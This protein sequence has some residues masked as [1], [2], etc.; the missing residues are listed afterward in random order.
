MPD[1]AFCSVVEDSAAIAGW[2]IASE[3]HEPARRRMVRW[4]V[5]NQTKFFIGKDVSMSK[6]LKKLSIHHWS[7]REM[8]VGSRRILD[9]CANYMPQDAYVAGKVATGRELVHEMD[10]A[11]NSNGCN[12]LTVAVREKHNRRGDILVGLTGMLH[13]LASVSDKPEQVAKSESLLAIIRQQGHNI[14]RGSYMGASSAIQTILKSFDKP[15]NAAIIAEL[16]LSQAVENLRTSQAGFEAAF[17]D[18]VTIESQDNTASTIGL[19]K[20]LWSVLADLTTYID[21]RADAEPQAMEALVNKLNEQIGE[22]K[23]IVRARATRNQKGNTAQATTGGASAG[24][25]ASTA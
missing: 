18:K 6:K 3:I 15:E 11:L 7:N 12:P 8:H 9:E 14:G 19:R 21:Y 10:M 2:Q 13:G 23:T 16:G 20:N 4:F 1:Q 5:H 17:W 24:K 25:G 22:I